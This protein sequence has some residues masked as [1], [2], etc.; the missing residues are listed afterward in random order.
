MKKLILT[1]ALIFGMIYLTSAQSTTPQ[2]KQRQRKQIHRIE[3]GAASGQLTPAETRKLAR[4]QKRIQTHKR[5]AKADGTVTPAERRS[6]NREQNRANR[7]IYY[8]KHN[9]RGRQ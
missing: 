8:Q 6:L 5:I 3:Q 7:Q 9:G 1:F 2:V 4:Q